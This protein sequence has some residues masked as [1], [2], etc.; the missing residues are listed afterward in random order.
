MPI[1]N[2]VTIVGKTPLR[3]AG[4][5]AAGASISAAIDLEGQLLAGIGIPN[6]ASWT[7][8]SMTLQVSVDGGNLYFDFYRDGA[9]F[10][11]SVPTGRTNPT[12]H[13]VSPQD[14][15]GV[16]HLKVRSGTAGTP[17]TQATTQ[18]LSIGRMP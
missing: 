4:T 14:F 10:T 11:I 12:Y 18:S 2:P 8:A 5:I 3:A 16:T 9:E 7:D 17:V 13:P 15:I 1:A 6:S